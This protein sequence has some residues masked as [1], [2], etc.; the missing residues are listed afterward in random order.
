MFYKGWAGKM[1]IKFCLNQDLNKRR[2]K[3][4]AS[5]GYTLEKSTVLVITPLMV[6]FISW[7]ISHSPVGNFPKGI[8]LFL[9]LV[10]VKL[11]LLF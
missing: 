7:L 10:V 4:Q 11:L 6:I 5:I 1:I 2:E 8:F 3:L 9:F